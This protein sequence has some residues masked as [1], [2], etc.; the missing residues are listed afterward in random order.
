[1]LF[2]VVHAHLGEGGGVQLQS[3]QSFTIS[4]PIHWKIER[5]GGPD[6]RFPPL[7]QHMLRY[8]LVL[9]VSVSVFC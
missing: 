6:P 2:C 7:D 8:S 5:G 9:L 3:R 4:E 1:M